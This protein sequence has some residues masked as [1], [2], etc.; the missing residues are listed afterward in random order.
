MRVEEEEGEVEKREN[1]SFVLL[2][3]ALGEFQQDRGDFFAYF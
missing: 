2:A 1:R 3:L